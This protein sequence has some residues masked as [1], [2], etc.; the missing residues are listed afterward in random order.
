[1]I[2]INPRMTDNNGNRFIYN[3][4]RNIYFNYKFD[5]KTI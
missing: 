4:N 1:M 2:D 3:M 5:I